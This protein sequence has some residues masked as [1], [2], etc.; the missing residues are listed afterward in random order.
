MEREKA[1]KNS[2]IEVKKNKQTVLQYYSTWQH[3]FNSKREADTREH[4]I[5]QNA[6]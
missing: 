5:M 1:K 4:N 2:R 6:T 3:R